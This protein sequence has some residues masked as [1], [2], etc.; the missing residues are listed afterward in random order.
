V[1]FTLDTYILVYAA[2]RQTDPR[3]AAGT[4]L[5]F[6][7]ASADCVLTLQCLGE[8]FNVAT[9]RQRVAPEQAQAFVDSCRTAFLVVAGK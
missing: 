4:S 1:K 3:H 8:F 9:R 5:V 2:N 7:A 6:R